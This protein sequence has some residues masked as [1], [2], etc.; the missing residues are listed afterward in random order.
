[1]HAAEKTV[2]SLP[3]AKT[4]SVEPV[5]A[6]IDQ[7]LLK[8]A[9]SEFDSNWY[10]GCYRHEM[11]FARLPNETA[12]K[13][14]L[15]VGGRAGHDPNQQ[16][17]EILYR[18]ANRDV[19]K[20]L[21]LAAH[22][23]AFLHWLQF[24]QSEPG[25]LP[26]DRRLIERVREMVKG[27][28][29]EFLAR[30][31]RI[32]AAIYPHPVDYYFSH[33]KPD[34][35][36]PSA[37]FSEEGYIALNPDTAAG[38]KSEELLCGYDHYLKTRANEKRKIIG[39]REFHQ[40]READLRRAENEFRQKV[41]HD[42]L[43]GMGHLAAFDMLRTMEY[44]CDPVHVE[45]APPESPGG[46]L[47]LVPH[48]LPEIIFGGYL[49][50]FECLQLLKDR[51]GVKLHLVVMNQA[52]HDVHCS[53]LIR[54][55]TEQPHLFH[56]FDH[57][58][59]FDS[60][61]RSVRCP[62]NFLVISYSAELHYL[63]QSISHALDQKPI[64][65]IQ[66]YEPDFHANTDMRSFSANAFL[67]PHTGLYNSAKLFEYF[68]KKTPVVKHHGASYRYAIF[69]NAIRPLSEDA[70]QRLMLKVKQRTKRLI[71][72]GRPEAHAARN[73]FAMFVCGLKTAIRAGVFA[74]GAW[75]FVSVGSLSHEATLDL[76]GRNKLQ[77]K[78]KMPKEDYENLLL[79]GDVGVSF[80]TTPHPGIIHFQMACFAL[81]T[82]TNV[83]DL[84]DAEWLGEQNGNLI[85]VDMTP[86]AIADGFRRAVDASYQRE[87]CWANA[88][89]VKLLT[90]EESYAPAVALLEDLVA[91]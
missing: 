46:L 2:E 61:H 62:Q 39:F 65:F 4:I 8:R 31:Y 84:R 40:L 27:I 3:K 38:I 51:T 11:R 45:L 23:T 74:D 70:Y 59:K 48:Y 26:K 15:R 90:K 37:E 76:D 25:R 81:P 7:A 91:G 32:D 52:P 64:F 54:M 22:M 49:A 33:V 75:E 1:M 57:I 43:P 9:E 36:S 63:A 82:V 41:L 29:A 10:E 16:F 53:N 17:S 58:A 30:H 56:L 87:K 69:E 86:A 88:R 20:H 18:Q 24:R 5:S 55:R 19:M 89:R 6:A 66:E 79:S 85:G 13:Y 47:V 78:S 77:I 67:I 21:V 34:M 73:H 80:I 71:F 83:T 72:Y 42:N 60:E 14:Y 12:F 28:D 35:V 50:F 44:Y 68:E